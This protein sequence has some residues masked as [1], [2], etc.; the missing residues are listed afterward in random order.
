MVR[1]IATANMQA[2]LQQQHAFLDHAKS[3][4]WAAVKA[5]L[6]ADPNLVNVTPSD[7][8][9][10]LHQAAL[11][12]DAEAVKLLL[13]FGADLRSRATHEDGTLKTPRCAATRAY[14]YRLP[15]QTDGDNIY[16]CTPEAVVV[17]AGSWL[18]RR[19]A[20]ARSCSRPRRQLPTWRRR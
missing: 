4:D 11:S 10:A 5:A 6:I 9:S 15:H 16:V 12:G 20:P 14:A 17:W 2:Q 3:F 7:R 1:E 18:I 19:P 13:R 8:W